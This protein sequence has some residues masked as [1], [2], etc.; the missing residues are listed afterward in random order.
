MAIVLSA[1]TFDEVHTSA[2]EKHEE[3]GGRDGRRIEISGVIAGEQTVA[4]VE[5]KLDAILAAASAEDYSS[6]LSL[7]AGRQL[8]VRRVQFSRD[9]SPSTRVGSFVLAVE[10]KSPFEESVDARVTEW[11]ISTQEA[12]LGLL[13]QGNACALPVLTVVASGTLVNPSFSDGTRSILFSGTVQ[14]GETLVL[15]CG[16]GR[17]TLEGMDVTA[18]TT[19]FFPR[20]APGGTTLRWADSTDSSHHANVTITLRD[21]WW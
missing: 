8:W 4:G 10:A 20:V 18:Y 14:D 13:T 7:R 17:A 15:D 1:V 3:V 9:V 11:P 16:E 12:E 6:A 21:R 2:R 5:A 19:G